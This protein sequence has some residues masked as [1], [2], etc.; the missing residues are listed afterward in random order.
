MGICCKTLIKVIVNLAVSIGIFPCVEVV[1]FKACVVG[2][3]VI[4]SICVYVSCAGRSNKLCLGCLFFADLDAS[5]IVVMYLSQEVTFSFGGIYFIAVFI[6]V[7]LNQSKHRG[8][9][10]AVAKSYITN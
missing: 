5:V 9:P 7:L 1:G 8:S 6:V 2:E 3:F 10:L 4:A